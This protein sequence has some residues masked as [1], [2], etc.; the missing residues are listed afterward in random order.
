ML[1]QRDSCAEEP[2]LREV[3]YLALFIPGC[4]TLVGRGVQSCELKKNLFFEILFAAPIGT[5]VRFAGPPGRQSRL[6]HHAVLNFYVEILGPFFGGVCRSHCGK[7]HTENSRRNSAKKFGG[8]FLFF[9]AFF[10]LVF[11]FVWPPH[12]LSTFYLQIEKDSRGIRFA[13]NYP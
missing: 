1:L 8:M 11:A 3:K 7:T 5:L 9:A 6:N 2:H 13:R 10:A 12:T 4:T